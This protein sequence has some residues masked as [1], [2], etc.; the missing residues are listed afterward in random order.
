MF[1]R[2]AQVGILGFCAI[3]VVAIFGFLVVAS[4]LDTP[5][6]RDF[7]PESQKTLITTASTA[8]V[9]IFGAAAARFGGGDK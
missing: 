5:G 4:V 8:A 9:G 6:I 7:D 3:A 2:I 1:D